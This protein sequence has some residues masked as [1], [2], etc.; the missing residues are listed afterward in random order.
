MNI[1]DEYVN[2]VEGLFRKSFSSK[3]N[4]TICLYGLGE[5][6]VRILKLQ[7]FS[8]SGVMGKERDSGEWHDFPIL[9]AKKA[10]RS[11]DLM[12][13]V[14]SEENTRTIYERIKNEISLDIYNCYGELLKEKYTEERLLERLS[15]KQNDS[16][17]KTTK[18]YCERIISDAD[19][20]SFDIFDTLL[21]RYVLYSNDVYQITEEYLKKKF[22]GYEGFAQKRK[23]ADVYCQNNHLNYKLPEIYGLLDDYSED[24]R[25][26]GIQAETDLD[27]SV[28]FGKR[29]TIELLQYAIEKG[30][31]VILVSDMY[32]STTT[33]ERFLKDF[34]VPDYD[35]LFVSC[36]Y[37]KSKQNGDLFELVQNEY[38][39]KKI[40]HIGDSLVGDV[41]K[42]LEWGIEAFQLRNGLTIM[43]STEFYILE[44]YVKTL[45]DSLIL[46]IFVA[47]FFGSPFACSSESGFMKHIDRDL[48][49][50]WSSFA[51]K[52][53]CKEENSLENNGVFLRIG[54][55]SKRFD[56]NNYSKELLVSIIHSLEEYVQ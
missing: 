56:L 14:A 15:E 49:V 13:I 44:A 29:A 34:G 40:I 48:A 45:Y 42:P 7:E 43:R 51:S 37:G 52:L 50:E 18:E 17:W 31:T 21:G 28:L 1:N 36:E 32:Y 2:D 8:F 39:G 30:K 23:D 38:K 12:V 26:I 5:K 16:Y 53:I 27:A 54:K 11:S 20:V 6:T 19:V 55:L 4:K 25:N 3:S 24:E 46:G 33:L 35:R 22:A 41:E 47:D 10:E 9:D